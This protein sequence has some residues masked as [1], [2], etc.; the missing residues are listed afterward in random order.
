[1]KIFGLTGGI[2]CGKSTVSQHWAQQGLPIIDA[3]LISRKCVDPNTKRGFDA[4]MKIKEVFGPEVFCEDILDRKALGR[5][6]FANQEKKKLLE[7]ILETPYKDIFREEVMRYEEAGFEWVCYD[8]AMLV[9]QSNWTLYRPV[10]VVHV[11]LNIQMQRLLDRN[12]VLTSKEAKA[13]VLSQM[14]SSRR[15]RYADY[16]IDNSGSVEETLRTAGVVLR[17]IK[18]KWA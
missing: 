7:G 6:V 4:L 16:A 12:P 17:E 3:D 14:P 9:E 2:A 5:I 18:S 10:V 15:L 1:M 8:D 11:P 13:R